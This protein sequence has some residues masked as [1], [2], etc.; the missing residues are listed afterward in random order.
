MEK[1]YQVLKY[2]QGH[3]NTT[4]IDAYVM[5][6]PIWIIN[7]NGCEYYLMFCENDSIIKLCKKSYDIILEYEK[8]I[9]YKLT[10]YK[11]QNG[12]IGT[13]T[14]NEERKLI[15]MHQIIMDC[16]GNGKGTSNVSVDHIDQNPLNNTYE[17]LR[18]ATRKEQ[19]QN[20]KGIKPGTKRE[21]QKAAQPLPEGITHDM[22]PKYLV[23]YKN[24]LNKERTKYREY[25][26]IERHPLLNDRNWETTK[27][28]KISIHE[29][30]QSA[31]AVLQ[32]LNAGI[33]PEKEESPLPKYVYHVESEKGEALIYERR[34]SDKRCNVR[35]SLPKEYILSEQVAKLNEKVVKK[36]GE[37]Y[38]IAF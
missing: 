23:Y 15:Y 24:W 22:L 17:N 38:A 20:S 10:W 2:I 11:L 19:E 6:N 29:K 25:F 35:M 34:N 8:K 18:I 4:G 26:R 28:E 36:Y 37:E 33:L 30:L 7:E 21:R 14:P 16:Y 9:D 5:K 12:Y 31:L 13:H 32:N 27:S 3:Y 1:Q